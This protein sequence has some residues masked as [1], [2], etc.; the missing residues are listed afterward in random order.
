MAGSNLIGIPSVFFNIDEKNLLTQYFLAVS[1]A[2][3]EQEPGMPGQA[4]T[5]AKRVRLERGASPQL[6][7]IFFRRSRGHDQMGL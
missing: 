4:A 7:P 5:G 1:P 6:F 3:D 2:P